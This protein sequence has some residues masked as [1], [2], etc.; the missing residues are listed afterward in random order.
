[1]QS[2][3]NKLFGQENENVYNSVCFFLLFL[4]QY[5]NKDEY[6]LKTTL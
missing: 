3:C 5:T 6:N 2:P 4:F 1:M